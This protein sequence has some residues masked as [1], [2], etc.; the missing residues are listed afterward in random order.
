MHWIIHK[1][2]IVSWYIPS[3]FI[4]KTNCATALSST[5]CHLLVH[6]C[7]W[8]PASP[9]SSCHKVCW[10]WRLWWG[11]SCYPFCIC[12]FDEW[13]VHFNHVM[14]LLISGKIGTLQFVCSISWIRIWQ[15]SRSVFSIAVL[16]LLTNISFLLTLFKTSE[17]IPPPRLLLLRRIYIPSC[18]TAHWKC[19]IATCQAAVAVSISRFCLLP[20]AGSWP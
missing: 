18:K 13:L 6:W 9:P 2:E 7:W 12:N 17:L 4:Q 16:F 19:I 5:G 1:S 3:R 15:R 10:L 11:G 8:W 20:H 14:L